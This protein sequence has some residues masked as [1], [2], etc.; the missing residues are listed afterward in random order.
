MVIFIEKDLSFKEGFC[1][2]SLF[3]FHGMVNGFIFSLCKHELFGVS[4]IFFL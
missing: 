1:F 4:K 2:V 3:I